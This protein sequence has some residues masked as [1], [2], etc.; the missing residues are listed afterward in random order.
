LL[1]ALRPILARGPSRS[2]R[3]VEV[4]ATIR[5]FVDE[6]VWEIVEQPIGERQVEL[7]LVLDH[8]PSMDMWRSVLK[9]LRR[10]LQSCGA[11]RRVDVAW[12]VSRDGVPRLIRSPR[13]KD[14]RDPRAN[15]A[16]PGAAGPRLCLV[17]T[18]CVSRSWRL[19]PWID[20][21]DRW[22]PGATVALLQVL[23]EYQWSRTALAQADKRRASADRWLTPNRRFRT[24]AGDGDD[25]ERLLE[26]AEEAAGQEPAASRRRP[27]YGRTWLPVAS[28]FESE[29]VPSL[30]RFLA[31]R[32]GATAMCYRLSRPAIVPLTLRK[33]PLEALKVFRMRASQSARHLATLLAASP[34][35]S[36]PL[37]RI[38][39]ETH[40]P[41]EGGPLIEADLWLGGLLEP[42]EESESGDPED[43]LYTFREGIR[44]Q[45]LDGIPAQLSLQILES[46][47]RYIEENLGRLGGFRA[48]L[49]APREHRGEL[50]AG[51]GSDPIARV[52]AQIL[53]RQ[54]PDL[55]GLVAPSE[56]TTGGG[57]DSR[58]GPPS[59]LFSAAGTCSRFAWSPD[60]ELLAI[61]MLSG[62]LALAAPGEVDVGRVRVS[63]AG[64]N[65][66]AWSP[67]GLT[68][69]IACYSRV[70][71]LFN[72]KLERVD[73]L[74]GH[75]SDVTAVAFSPE[76]AMLAS[77]TA[78]GT[79]R[80]WSVATRSN[81]ALMYFGQGDI[82]SLC[83]LDG[84]H[85][86]AACANRTMILQFRQGRVEL[87]TELEVG[88][89]SLAVMVPQRPSRTSA[90]RVLILG[91][92]NGEVRF[93]SV[94]EARWL[95]G[96]F[97]HH[98][99]ITAMSVSDDGSLLASKSHDG[100]VVV[101]ATSSRQIV[102]TL[103]TTPS[104]SPYGCVAFRPRTHVLAVAGAA[105]REIS[106]H[107][108]AALVPPIPPPPAALHI[109]MVGSLARGSAQE[110][111]FAD[112]CFQIGEELA[113][114]EHVLVIS[115][116][117]ATAA[118]F[119]A[120][121]GYVSTERVGRVVFARPDDGLAR[122]YV[123]DLEARIPWRRAILDEDTRRELAESLEQA[124]D[125]KGL[126]SVMAD[127][128]ET[129]RPIAPQGLPMSALVSEVLRWAEGQ[130]LV[131][132]LVDAASMFKPDD[133]R[134]KSLR[135]GLFHKSVTLE[136]QSTRERRWSDASEREIQES[137]DAVI[138]VGGKT[139]T[140]TAWQSATDRVPVIPVPGFG[141]TADAVWEEA[142]ES[143]RASGIEQS[144]LDL[145]NGG[146]AAG[147]AGIVVEMAEQAVANARASGA[148][149]P[150]RTAQVPE[151]YN[152]VLWVDDRPNNCVFPRGEFEAAG[153][154][155][156][157]ALSTFGGAGG[158]E[159]VPLRSHHLGHAEAGGAE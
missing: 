143:L 39:Q 136:L 65:Q 57:D 90:A 132:E 5:R 6:G 24:D 37:T 14:S 158:P 82:R 74:K 33:G 78:G 72:R 23:P 154:R 20:L 88:A 7:L 125:I 29:S 133:D 85:V 25:L 21:L 153:L 27:E 121:L 122:G 62:E 56:G 40:M 117:N 93:W 80:L 102:A 45:L 107:D 17:A 118:D 61:P 81:V 95:P 108:M 150:Q 51:P 13:A 151:G 139:R 97:P 130:G 124:F 11:F 129:P 67:D 155:F 49:S 135:D 34:A 55:A 9:E 50:A 73:E 8:S 152:H 98:A 123:R 42:I 44:E 52:A 63:G 1:R 149:G 134:L 110:A 100:T 104:S 4:D 111:S 66:A 35:I 15:P 127:L 87:V 36:L 32:A 71:R 126:L 105:D 48:L 159:A 58:I 128:V 41:G 92:G 76:G 10:A 53:R 94:D 43:V 3:Q 101:S 2:R 99:R 144:R 116:G 54:A 28:L 60:G 75:N 18:D 31:G 22:S 115:S 137:C 89:S 131:R 69:A 59:P 157:L 70:V 86:A 83:W 141:G 146:W 12:L 114:R 38:V 79:V 142:S 47:S 106:L 68:I 103:T 138:L 140:R 120:F 113:R 19:A 84:T 64:L 30:A 91:K 156:T 96:F 109:R 26:S 145:L 77:G 46:T 147:H 119:H 112:A 16:P 148:G